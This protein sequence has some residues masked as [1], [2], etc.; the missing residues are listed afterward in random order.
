ML[1]CGDILCAKCVDT[2]MKTSLLKQSNEGVEIWCPVCQE[3][4]DVPDKLKLKIQQIKEKVRE[5]AF[6]V[7]CNAHPE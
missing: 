6:V 7:Y 5:Q 2:N 4:S 1:S 3:S